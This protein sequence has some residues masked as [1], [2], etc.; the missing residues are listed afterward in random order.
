MAII[1]A[2]VTLIAITSILAW[3]GWAII[4]L[5]STGQPLK[6]IKLIVGTAQLH[7]EL[8]CPSDNVSTDLNRPGPSRDEASEGSTGANPDGQ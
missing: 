3:F 4:K 8:Y 1:V 6:T 2:S 7:V 5:R